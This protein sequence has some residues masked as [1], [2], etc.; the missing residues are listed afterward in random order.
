M[1]KAIKSRSGKVIEPNPAMTNL[2]IEEIQEEFEL[3]RM[4]QRLQQSIEHLEKSVLKTK[5]IVDK[6]DSSEILSEDLLNEL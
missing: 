5:A 2:T 1:L 3:R 4:N 6:I